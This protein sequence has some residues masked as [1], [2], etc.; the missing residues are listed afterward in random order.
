MNPTFKAPGIYYDLD[1][2]LVDDEFLE[3]YLNDSACIG[4]YEHEDAKIHLD[5]TFQESKLRHT[6]Y[7]EISHHIIQTLQEIKGKE[8][9]CDVL[10]RYL[11]ALGEKHQEIKSKL[12]K[13]SNELK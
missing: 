7:H 1:V 6:F 8:D 11:D 10:A 3:V 9:K 4:S 2:Y 5:G 12:K 13:E